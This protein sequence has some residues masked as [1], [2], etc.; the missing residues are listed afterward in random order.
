M[1]LPILSPSRLELSH[2]KH[3]FFTRE[4]GVSEGY[5]G[6]LNCGQKHD[7]LENV[8]ENRRRIVSFLGGKAWVGLDQKHTAKA[9]F[10]DKPFEGDAPTADAIVTMTPGLVIAILTADCA[11]ILLADRRKNIIAA[12][13]AGWQGAFAGV[14]ENTLRLMREKGAEDIIASIGPCIH[15][16]SYEMGV[17][18]K[19][20]FENALVSRY[21]TFEDYFKRNERNTFQFDLPKFVEGI[22]HH[23]AVT[24]APSHVKNPCFMCES[25]KREGERMGN[26]IEKTCLY[27]S[28]T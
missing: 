3:G 25:S 20:K 5:L 10:I 21:L 7:K 11:P 24:A 27:S 4:G 22:L 15:Q 19:E 14:I 26:I 8:L 28:Y 13:H 2:I 12:V 6:S 23:H 16:K 9:I 1:I 17:E 18:F